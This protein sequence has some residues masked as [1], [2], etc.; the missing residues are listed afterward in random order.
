M[1]AG[2]SVFPG[3]VAHRGNAA[4]FPENTL[5]AL[6]S[7]LQLGI[8]HLEF[9]VHL[10]L[11]HV[12]IVIHDADLKRTA[13]IEGN[14]LTMTW[15]QLADVRVGEP[16]R[17]GARYSDVA[18]PSLEQVADLV[19]S[20]PEARAFVELKR[21]SLRTFGT[22]VMVARVCEVLQPVASQCVLISFDLPAVTFARTHAHLPIGW[23]LPEADSL[24]AL[25]CE[26]LQPEYLFCDHQKLG[27]LPRLWKGPWQWVIY[28]VAERELALDLKARG[29]D[30]VE[31][32]AVREMAS[33]F[34]GT[35][36]S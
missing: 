18:I 24:A 12:P 27:H 25:K 17:F 14:P 11:D 6:E 33:A 20:H 32:M 7:A 19:S 1:Q 15:Q 8:A 4:E 13:G 31:T 9:D 26:A 2:T 22:D 34:K 36:A 21:T 10:T 29:A 30:F 23:V 3:I 5:P 28:E 35:T 16:A